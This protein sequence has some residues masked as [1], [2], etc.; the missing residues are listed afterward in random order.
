MSHQVSRKYLENIIYLVL[1]ALIMV[2]PIIS[3]ALSE[4]TGT[5]NWSRVF[6]VWLK[7][8][9]FFI[10]FLIHNFLLIPILTKKK[11]YALYIALCIVVTAAI[12]SVWPFIFPN[13]MTPPKEMMRDRSIPPRDSLHLEY[14]QG[15][16]SGLGSP[17]ADRQGLGGPADN[18][19]RPGMGGPADNQGRPG[20]GGP[21]DNQGR[22]GMGGPADNQGRPGMG[23]P[24][25]NQGRPGMGGP[26]DNQGRPGMGP[27]QGNAHNGKP[28]IAHPNLRRMI[29]PFDPNSVLLSFLVGIMLIGFNIAI[30]LIMK[31]IDDEHRMKEL[32]NAKLQNE[33]NYLKAQLN[34]H[35]FMNTLNN[36]HALVD[37]DSEKAKTTIIEFSK[38]MRFVL[39]EADRPTIDVSK[40]VSFIT[41]YIKLMELRYT[42]EVDITFDA[43]AMLPSADIPPLLFV[44]FLE[45]A[46]KYGV[47]YNERSYIHIA[48]EI[49]GDRLIYKVANS[50][51]PPVEVPAGTTQL[52]KS[53]GIGIANSVKRLELL[54]GSN[55]YLDYGVK[56]DEYSVMLSIPF[57]AKT[58]SA[59]NQTI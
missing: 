33:L 51:W 2:I 19:G 46:F 14:P 9:P 1:W 21:V 42:S 26:A 30:K 45:N 38:L 35:F 15:G 37:I 27:M 13:S 55:Y 20:M 41:N 6:S 56:D 57:K 31:S 18:Q 24:V 25:D 40:E 28:Q 50:Y 44:S 7:I 12:V 34:P 59:E 48:M 16:A 54:Y 43:P 11:N 29:D 4:S 47:R 53:G 5:L 23:G 32:E 36:I 22:P 8:L 17:P 49:V 39:Y 52:P 3:I 10:L 58:E